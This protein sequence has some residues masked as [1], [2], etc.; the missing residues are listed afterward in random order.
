[1][2]ERVPVENEVNMLY[3]F[4]L[5]SGKEVYDVDEVQIVLQEL[6]VNKG[7]D[8]ASYSENCASVFGRPDSFFLQIFIDI[9]FPDR[10][11]RIQRRQAQQRRV[12]ILS[13]IPKLFEYVGL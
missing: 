4:S 12:A 13:V 5:F 9:C 10:C 3:W 7:A 2:A 1:M 11:N 8:P 6:D